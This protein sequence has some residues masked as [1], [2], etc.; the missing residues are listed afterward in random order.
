[1]QHNPKQ[2]GTWECGFYVMLYMKH[3]IESHDTA[4]LNPKEV[5]IQNFH[6]TYDVSTALQ[7]K[8]F[9]TLLLLYFSSQMFKSEKNYG[10]SEIDEIRKEWISY[11]SPILEKY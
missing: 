10:M 1:M 2:T 6:S 8:C 3:I 9:L 5:V 7:Y 11:V 4:M